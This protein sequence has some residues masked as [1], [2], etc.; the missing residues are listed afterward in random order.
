MHKR[1]IF[2]LKKCIAYKNAS[3]KKEKE[4]QESSF[5]LINYN[6]TLIHQM[7]PPQKNYKINKFEGDIY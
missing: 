1:F 5:Q 4:K 6:H 2:F 3:L 7:L